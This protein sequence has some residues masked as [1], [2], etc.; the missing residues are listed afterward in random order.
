MSRRHS[1]QVLFDGIGAEGQER[2]GRACVAV[3]GCGA[4]GTV[5]AELLV[6]AG[7]ARLTIIDRDVVELSNLQRQSLFT[8]RDAA[9]SREKAL[10]A[11]TAL[12]EI[13]SSAE[14]RPLVEDLVPRNAERL[15]A[16]HQLIV[17]ATDN[18]AARFL[19]ND[20]AWKLGIPWIYGAAVGA[21]GTFGV[22]RPGLTPCL[23]CLMESLPPPGSTPTCETSGVIGPVTHLVASLQVSEALKLLVGAEPMR[24]IGL[25]SL[26][27][28]AGPSVRSVLSNASPW[29]ACP[30]CALSSYP[31]LA[32]EGSE[33]ARALCGRNSVQLV[34]ETSR[35]IDLDALSERLAR[36]GAVT[37]GEESLTATFEETSITL[38]RDGRAI[39]TGTL[40]PERG[41]SLFS[42]YIGV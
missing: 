29:T 34:P 11:S 24:G 17:D 39:V 41:R 8:E 32:G 28:A 13:D 1:R 7:V 3:V 23:R 14:I 22:F 5:A 2:I 37:R 30:T 33:F 36:A 6:R 12:K 20:V 26:W 40:D 10:A 9:G 25:V 4:L 38:F 19:I 16:G 18:F 15:L 35:T 42:R 31:A 21:E 27:G